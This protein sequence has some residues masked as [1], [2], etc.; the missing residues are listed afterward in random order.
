MKK[1]QKTSLLIVFVILLSYI[2]FM[3]PYFITSEPSFCGLCH[4]VKPYVT[5]W[6][7]SAHKEVKCLFC[8]EYR[9]FVGKLHSKSRGLNYVYQHL[10]GQYT[11]ITRAQIF[12]QNC[13]AC[14]L[15]D[16]SS[17]PKATRLDRKHFDFI[18]NNK[19]CLDCHRETGHKI[20]I[21][22]RE[23]FK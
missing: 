12:E 21:F 7:D 1:W 18:K 3:V 23:K 14:H 20:N 4:E 13:I 2:A 9:G 16:Y 6:N 22:S 10:T 8:H 11:I 5:S 15:G 19:P 17:Y